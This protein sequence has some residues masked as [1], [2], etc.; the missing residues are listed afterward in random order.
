[1][2]KYIGDN[3]TR[4]SSADL[5][6]LC[7]E[8]YQAAQHL[9]RDEIVVPVDEEMGRD[10]K[11]IFHPDRLPVILGYWSGAEVEQEVMRA[12]GLRCGEHRRGWKTT[13]PGPWFT[14]KDEEY[15]H[16]RKTVEIL[17]PARVQEYLSPMEALVLS[18][19]EPVL[20]PV[21]TA[22]I[23]LPILRRAGVELCYMLAGEPSA[24]S[25]FALYHFILY[26]LENMTESKVRLRDNVQTRKKPLTSA[27]KIDRMM[28]TYTS[29]GAASGMN[30]KRWALSRKAAEYFELWL[31]AERQRRK[32]VKA[33]VEQEEVHDSPAIALRKLAEEFDRR[34]ALQRKNWEAEEGE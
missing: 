32:L 9:Q 16:L 13:V 28:Q 11:F 4:Y 20:P 25:D 10:W 18:G 19:E 34:E 33:G 24:R 21:L 17:S 8:V 26:Y 12:Y 15:H 30:W 6:M 31:K 27:E 22:Q 3:R 7:E 14:R 2:S 23:L 1:M 5:E 29:G